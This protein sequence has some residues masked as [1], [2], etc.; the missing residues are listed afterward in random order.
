MSIHRGSFGCGETKGAGQL[1]RWVVEAQAQ[2]QK[3]SSG[4]W[5][6]WG[7]EGGRDKEIGRGTF[8]ISTGRRTL[9]LLS[10]NFLL[11]IRE[12]GGGWELG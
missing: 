7:T 12:G 4:L 10:P 6:C 1:V 8:H 9:Y 3:G 2:V 11:E 5:I